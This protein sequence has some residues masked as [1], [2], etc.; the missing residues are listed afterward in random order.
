MVTETVTRTF[1]SDTKVDT[2]VNQLGISSFGGVFASTGTTGQIPSLNSSGKL[3]FID[4]P[5]GSGS[6]PYQA[7][8]T[9]DGNY[10]LI[11]SDHG[12]MILVTN[13]LGLDTII[14]TLPTGMP[15]GFQ[16]TIFSDLTQLNAAPIQF[17][18]TSPGVIKSAGSSPPYLN[19]KTA[20][21]ATHVANNVWIVIGALL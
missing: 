18:A 4:A 9:V 3:T 19:I 6:V 20:A 15:A 13:T 7:F 10:T 14:L 11:A 17:S 21:Y 16:V 8:K 2:R 1:Y 5:S 12:N